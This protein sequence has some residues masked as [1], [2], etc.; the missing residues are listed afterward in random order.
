MKNWFNVKTGM[1]LSSPYI[2][3]NEFS[4]YVRNFQTE[5]ALLPFEEKKK[6]KNTLLNVLVEPN[7]HNVVKNFKAGSK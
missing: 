1:F 2:V 5:Y 4:G 7:Q 6:V 3:R